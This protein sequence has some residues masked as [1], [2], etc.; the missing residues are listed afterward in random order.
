LTEEIRVLQIKATICKNE[1]VEIHEAYTIVEIL[2][3]DYKI[4]LS[5]NA[6]DFIRGW[7][8]GIKVI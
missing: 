4:Y 7:H 2:E 8:N 3:E 1:K 6:K 5:D